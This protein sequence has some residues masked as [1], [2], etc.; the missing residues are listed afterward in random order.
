[1]DHIVVFVVVV[2]VVETSPSDVD[3]PTSF[4]SLSCLVATDSF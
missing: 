3:R 1:L 4:R 2:V